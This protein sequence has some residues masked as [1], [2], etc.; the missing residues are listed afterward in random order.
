MK[1]TVFCVGK[2]PDHQEPSGFSLPDNKD[3]VLA[4]PLKTLPASLSLSLPRHFLVL[5]SA[6]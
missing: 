4:H 3:P 6:D 1:G 2:V 5:S